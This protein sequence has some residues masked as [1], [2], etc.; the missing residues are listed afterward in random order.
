METFFNSIHFVISAKLQHIRTK[1]YQ[2]KKGAMTLSI[3]TFSIMTFGIM[4]LSIMTLSI[5]TFSKTIN[6]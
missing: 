5:M 1:N 4:T 6:K 3:M 2:N